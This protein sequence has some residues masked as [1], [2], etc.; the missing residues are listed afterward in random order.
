MALA[1]QPSFFFSALCIVFAIC[2][3]ILDFL[4]TT[5]PWF[6]GGQ[7]VQPSC[8]CF[9]IFLICPCVVLCVLSLFFLATCSAT[10]LYHFLHLAYMSIL[11]STPIQLRTAS[12]TLAATCCL[13][14][15]HTQHHP[16]SDRPVIALQCVWLP[17]QKLALFSQCCF[18]LFW[19]YCVTS[20]SFR[21]GCSP[22][23]VKAV[24][25]VPSV[26]FLL[27]S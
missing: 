7:Y 8:P 4:H 23:P 20:Y 15:K 5:S 19:H 9:N 2:L 22:Q 14:F 13:F 12:V 11:L 25:S 17:L 1:F 26:P 27:K 10:L 16:F 3:Q 6:R 21:L 18:S 24:L